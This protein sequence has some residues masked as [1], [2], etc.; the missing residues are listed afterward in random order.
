MGRIGITPECYAIPEEDSYG[1]FQRGWPVLSPGSRGRRPDFSPHRRPT[2]PACQVRHPLPENVQRQTKRGRRR[3]RRADARRRRRR[4]S[5]EALSDLPRELFVCRRLPVRRGGEVSRLRSRLF[6]LIL[7]VFYDAFRLSRGGERI[8]PLRE[9][10]F[11]DDLPFS[12]SV[13]HVFRAGFSFLRLVKDLSHA[14]FSLFRPGL[15]FARGAKAIAGEAKG[16]SRSVFSLF[17][18]RKGGRRGVKGRKRGLKPG[19][20]PAKGRK[21]GRRRCGRFSLGARV[22]VVDE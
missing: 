20:R 22:Q 18:P 17:R 21:R 9:K 2:G 7:P 4:E 12:R 16:K 3:A 15:R 1:G 6:R 10:A 14:R 19:E 11:W 8:F 13:R 5:G